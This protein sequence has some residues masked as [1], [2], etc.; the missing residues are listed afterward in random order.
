MAFA[1]RYDTANKT[2]EQVLSEFSIVHFIYSGLNFASSTSP[3]L[4]VGQDYL[5]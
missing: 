4:C 5:W 3:R 1:E 2:K